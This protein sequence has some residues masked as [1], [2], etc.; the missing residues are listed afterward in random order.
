MLSRLTFI[1][2][3][4]S[5]F[6]IPCA[7]C[8]DGE[9]P[10]Q[11]SIFPF[12]D[13]QEI[14]PPGDREDGEP[15]A[16]FS[17]L[18]DFL[19]RTNP[20]SIFQNPALKGLVQ[21]ELSSLDSDS[22]PPHSL[23]GTT[24]SAVTS[25][26]SPEYP[27]V[28]LSLDQMA[29]IPSHYQLIHPESIADSFLRN[30]VLEG[31]ND[32]QEWVLLSQ[33][34]DDRSLDEAG[35]SK[36]F[37]LDIDRPY[38][39][40]RLRVIGPNSDDRNLLVLAKIEFNGTLGG[41]QLSFPAT[42]PE[43]M[44]EI[45]FEPE[46]V[47]EQ[48]EDGGILGHLANEE[49]E[50]ANPA[51]LGRVQVISSGLA[52][53][54]PASFNLLSSPPVP[55]STTSIPDA[56]IGLRFPKGSGVAIGAYSL[57]LNPES[58]DLDLKDW[59]FEGSNDG[60]SW[61]VFHQGTE[62]GPDLVQEGVAT[63]I[64]RQ[65]PAIPAF[66]RFRVRSTGDHSKDEDPIVLY[67]I[68]IYGSIPDDDRPDCKPRQFDYVEDF[69]GRGIV[70]YFATFGG[71]QVYR[72]PSLTGQIQTSASSL[73]PTSEPAFS[74]VGNEVVRCVTRPL[75][76]S[77][78]EISFGEARIIPSHYSLRHYSSYDSEALRNWQLQASN[79]GQTWIT[80]REHLDDSSLNFA[81][82]TH[83]WA[84]YSPLRLSGYKRF[85]ILQ[86]GFNS[87]NHLNLALSG[88]EFYGT[89]CTPSP[90][91][92]DPTGSESFVYQED[93]DGNGIVS[94]LA[95]SGGR[96]LYLN[97]AVRGR[98]G[99]TSSSI[100]SDSMPATAAVGNETVR[101]VTKPLRDSWFEFDFKDI[102]IQ[103][104]HYTLRHYL[105]WDTEAL[106]SWVL[107]GSNDRDLWIT[108]ST[109]INDP[110]L[111]NKG[112]TA[113]WAIPLPENNEFFRFFRIRQTNR[114][115]NNHYYLALS[116]FEIY[117]NAKINNSKPETAPT[118][119][120]DFTYQ[121]DFDGNGLVSHLATNGRQEPYINPVRR[122]L[123]KTSSS[124]LVNDSQPSS[125]I[126]GNAS[127]RC[128]TKPISNSWFA[129]EFPNSSIRPTYYSLRHYSSWDTEALRNWELQG[130]GDGVH[131]ETLRVH[132]DDDSLMSAGDTASWP[133]AGLKEND[134]YSHFR[135]LQTGKN[136]NQ[137]H[138]LALSGFEI[139]GS[140]DTSIDL[141]EP[142][143]NEGGLDFD[144]GTEFEGIIHYL[145]TANG[146]RPFLNPATDGTIKTSASSLAQDS[147]PASSIA[148]QATV[149]CVTQAR[150]N[151]WM[152]VDFKDYRVRPTHYSLRHY[153]SWDTEALRFWNLEGSNDNDTWTTLSTHLNDTALDSKG[154]THTWAVDDTS[155]SYRY[156]RVI[157]T[158]R[159]SNQHFYLALSGIEFY[160]DLE[161]P[162]FSD[163]VVYNSWAR[164]Q[165]LPP[166]TAQSLSEDFNG[167]GTLN[168]EH[169]VFA[170][171]PKST[172]F[173]KPLIHSELTHV[174]QQ[175][176]GGTNSYYNVT[177]P[178]RG[179]IPLVDGRISGNGI[180]YR[181]HAARKP[182]QPDNL[183]VREISPA[184]TGELP[185]LPPGYLY[186]TFQIEEAIETTDSGFLWLEASP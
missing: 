147:L 117:G 184:L 67:G 132:Q 120:L 182:A 3:F 61:H 25:G 113:T 107:E 106:R 5:L 26:D 131:W 77:W 146:T 158:G 50:P 74:I 151:S 88:I 36:V 62:R 154:D 92:P 139:Y 1:A 153:S 141:S 70:A 159:N 143:P 47:G 126:L 169:F 48:D 134:F 27:S 140:V 57:N 123:A 136:S 46:A 28:T 91:E 71:E 137:H 72:N 90:P 29:F 149:R 103:P 11:S 102:T 20:D 180:N 82:D 73:D 183:T 63:W 19:G 185:P 15:R 111:Q 7:N 18:F 145:A 56:W 110:S 22:A 55:V 69:D 163:N 64:I 75:H 95:T 30:W 51:S 138:Y 115:S 166:G 8:Q 84:I 97:P 44:I 99:V 68:E 32:G 116:G 162:D 53:D 112:D 76:D 80:L 38:Q 171:N 78:F 87:N 122:G 160:G 34:L 125:A 21:I 161:G 168:F 59:L 142:Q 43:S 93:F 101:C 104:T 16:A 83:T 13:Q 94:F 39:A 96:E 100:M 31:S 186:R 35:A 45:P 148:G 114:N 98:L 6:S 58:N 173:S 164:D 176:G 119:G 124:S 181:F 165:G 65:D 23:L 49:E 177:F 133:I 52:P 54:S 156:F 108:L 66:E 2:L 170:S 150:P 179:A 157:Q 130:S 4:A 42:P 9:N 81:G 86:T 129:V 85:R 144:S 118:S 174:V 135:I 60:K 175:G 14:P 178:I 109:H 155:L 127:V 33:H 79:D 41:T 152:K 89:L 37:E 121:S 10:N 167:D 40:F 17:G 128:V 12:P 105:S 24:R 172:S